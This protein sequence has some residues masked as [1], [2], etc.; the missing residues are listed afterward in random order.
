MWYTPIE[1]IPSVCCDRTYTSCH[2]RIIHCTR[3]EGF[4]VQSDTSSC[5]VTTTCK[6]KKHKL[7]TDVLV[8]GSG[9]A[10]LY[11]AL[12]VPK[13]RQVLLITKEN[14]ESSDSYLAQ[15]GICMLRNDSD[16]AS[17]FKDT[18]RAGHQ[19][20]DPV[21]VDIMIRSSQDVIKNLIDYGVQF[22]R[23]EHGSFVFTRE[24]AHSQKRILFHKDITGKEIT[25]RLLDAVKRL[26]NV[27]MREYTT[28][29]DIVTDTC[30]HN[31][32]CESTFSHMPA[33]RSYEK[34]VDKIQR[35]RG[36]V[37]QNSTGEFEVAEADYTIFAT[38]G[39]GGLFKY[40]TNYSQLTGDAVALALK[41]GITT[42]HVNYIQVHPTTFYSRSQEERS[43]LISESVRGE[44]ARLYGKDMQ[45]FTNEL[46]PR[47]VLTQEI[48]KKMKKDN[49]NFVWE[50]LRPIPH[51]E[52]IHHFPH[53]VTYCA[54]HG[55]DVTRECIPVVPAQH[56]FMGGVKVNHESRTSM[57]HLYAIGECACNGVHGKNRLA[58][59]SLLEALVFAKR[60]ALDMLDT[61]EAISDPMPPVTLEQYQDITAIK[62][63]Y[64]AMIQKKIQD[65][66]GPAS[67]KIAYRA[68]EDIA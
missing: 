60:A 11:F 49:T 38:G 7:K 4:T 6:G 46:L 15:G 40:S 16:Y 1:K 62:R 57:A 30:P 28:M 64:A 5:D 10:A 32:R 26:P 51:D 59:N 25:S 31:G 14:F 33:S 20:N 43:F 44:G 19:E 66:G 35:C 58:S 61:Y 36:A 39:I 42:Q 54:E 34:K 53:I 29:V 22:E 55:F 12:H 68:L 3:R 63:R 23:D 47:D 27:A 65:E 21:S 18:M 45:R 24:G 9:C 50:D 37:I 41:H 52:L 2:V 67:A 13:D 56:Y 17:Y 8:V 48:L